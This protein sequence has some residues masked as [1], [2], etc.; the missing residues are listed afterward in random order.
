MSSRNRTRNSSSRYAGVAALDPPSQLAASRVA[1]IPSIIDLGSPTSHT[2]SRKRRHDED[3]EQS[4]ERTAKRKKPPSSSHH[5]LSSSKR[6]RSNKKA[7]PRNLKAPPPPAA[8]FKTTGDDEVPEDQKPETVTEKES[9]CICMCDL[10]PGSDDLALINGCEH[11]FCFGCIEKWSERENTCPLCKNRFT[12]I[13]RVNKKKKKGVKNSKKVKQRDQRSDII[14]G[15]AIEG[16][17]GK[18]NS[19]K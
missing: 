5:S 13:D 8:G 15:A 10:E 14:S 4:S 11:H 18:F 1:G 2:R 3:T 16:L 7:P 19:K 9:C 12:K 17:L 6:P